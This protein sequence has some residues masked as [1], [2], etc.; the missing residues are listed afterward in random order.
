[1]ICGFLLFA[2]FV[3]CLL[4]LCF[5]LMYVCV[6]EREREGGGVMVDLFCI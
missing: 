6:C 2:Q 4:V 3:C 1:M 5:L